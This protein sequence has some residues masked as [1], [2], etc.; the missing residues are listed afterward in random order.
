VKKGAIATTSTLYFAIALSSEAITAFPLN[1]SLEWGERVCQRER[2]IPN[3]KA[4]THAHRD[5]KKQGRGLKG[6]KAE[7]Y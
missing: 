7:G 3:R 5:A 4:R 1:F 6:K 2:S